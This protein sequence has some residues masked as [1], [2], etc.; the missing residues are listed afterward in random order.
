MNKTSRMPYIIG[1]FISI[2]LWLLWGIWAGITGNKGRLGDSPSVLLLWGCMG[3]LAAIPQ[4]DL[5]V[6]EKSFTEISFFSK[7][8]FLFTDIEIITI[9]TC[10]GRGFAVGT[11]IKNFCFAYTKANY[12]ALKEI[13]PLVKYSK[14]SVEEFEGMVKK[15][16]SAPS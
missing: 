10:G 2:G 6:N 13:I 12:A 16:F 14:I 15:T 7:K 1:S 4:H 11:M 8:E 5:L 3:L 9:G